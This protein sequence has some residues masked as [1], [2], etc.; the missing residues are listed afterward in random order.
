MQDS[1]HSRR[2][3]SGRRGARAAADAVGA[4]AA[5]TVRTGCD[6][7]VGGE[8]LAAEAQQPTSAPSERAIGPDG[9]GPFKVGM[10][11]VANRDQLF[12]APVQVVVLKLKAEQ[13]C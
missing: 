12:Q 3:R 11:G 4:L 7:A 1:V 13:N 5:V 8:G 6:I 2:T 9:L 10:A